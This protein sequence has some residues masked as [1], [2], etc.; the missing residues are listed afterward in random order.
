MNT[1]NPQ[2]LVF[3]LI[4]IEREIFPERT[5]S[6]FFTVRKHFGLIYILKEQD[7]FTVLKCP[8]I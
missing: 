8:Y 3:A 4:Q 6:K 7:A 2:S 5:F 1:S